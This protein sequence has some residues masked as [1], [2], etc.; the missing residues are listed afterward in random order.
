MTD[1]LWN[2]TTGPGVNYADQQAKRAEW[3]AKIKPAGNWKM[4]IRT[5]VWADEFEQCNQAA[6]WF[7]GAPLEVEGQRGKAVYV[8]SPGYYAT[9]GA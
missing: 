2:F 5:W 1:T 3:F 8:R 4:P 7:T 6:I 9:I